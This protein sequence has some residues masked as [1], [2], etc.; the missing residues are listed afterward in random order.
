MDEAVITKIMDL[1]E[2][3]PQGVY[4]QINSGIIDKFFKKQES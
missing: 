3:S 2:Y 1:F 4:S